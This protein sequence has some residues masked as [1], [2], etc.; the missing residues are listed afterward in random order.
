MSVSE[1]LI[2]E[3]DEIFSLFH[4]SYSSGIDLHSLV[5]D[6][7]KTYDFPCYEFS[8]GR[9]IPIV[10]SKV[11]GSSGNL[12]SKRNGKSILLSTVIKSLK[13]VSIDSKVLLNGK[14][15]IRAKVEDEKVIFGV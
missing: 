15:I 11:S 14:P 1:N 2:R 3:S 5:S 4:K 6:I 13:G 12:I 7:F 9:Y 10:S 8:G